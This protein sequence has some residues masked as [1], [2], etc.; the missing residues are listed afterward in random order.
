MRSRAIGILVGAVLCAG[1]G[2]RGDRHGGSA[3]PPAA[4]APGYVLFAPLLSGTTYLIDR[5]GRVVHTWE[6]DFA[7]GVS[8]HLLASG[9]LLRT[10]RR[11]GPPSFLG[12]GDGGRL[13][14]FDGDGRLV[15]EWVVAG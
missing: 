10:A 13:Q 7:P 1:T 8:A 15:W 6:S 2:C 9:H 5:S 11:N 4:F 14:E 12:G 3:G